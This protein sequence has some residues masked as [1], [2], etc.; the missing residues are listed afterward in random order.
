MYIFCTKHVHLLVKTCT[1][2]A[3]L[4]RLNLFLSTAKTKKTA[5]VVKKGVVA[6]STKRI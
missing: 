2:F 6:G 1:C 5:G 3:K 4:I